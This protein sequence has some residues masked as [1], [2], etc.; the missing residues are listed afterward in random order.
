MGRDT[1]ILMVP[2]PRIGYESDVVLLGEV[3][4]MVCIQRNQKREKL[5]LMST[6]CCRRA[7]FGRLS[8]PWSLTRLRLTSQITPPS[9]RVNMVSNLMTIS[10]YLRS[11][12]IP[13]VYAL[14]TRCLHP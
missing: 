11:W 12:W 3:P 4:N 5:D 1:H 14:S 13:C 10:I 8:G 6:C 9:G 7:L 2:I